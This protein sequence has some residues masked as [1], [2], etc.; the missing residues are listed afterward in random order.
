MAR[1]KYIRVSTNHQDTL[2]QERDFETFDEVFIDKASGKDTKRQGLE[3]MLKFVRKGD[4]LVVESYS[5]LARNTSDLLAIV[6]TLNK[7]GV[8]LIS[9]K[10]GLNTATPTGKLMLTVF[11]AL[12]TFEREILLERQQEGYAARRE[13]GLPL[14]RRKATTNAAFYKAVKKWRSGEIT[15]TA[16]MKE[17]GYTRTTFY[18]L[19]KEENL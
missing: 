1:V 5:R 13:A 18:K 8:V 17:C 16:A 2:R 6:E 10:E 9:E 14:G 19:V 4:T 11:G 3:D 7:K 15:A 12:A